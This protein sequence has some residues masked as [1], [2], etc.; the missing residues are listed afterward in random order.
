MCKS[1]DVVVLNAHPSFTRCSVQAGLTP[2]QYSANP[3]A[4]VNPTHA[5]TTSERQCSCIDVSVNDQHITFHDRALSD[6]TKM[7]V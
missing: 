1:F 3:G 4:F 6:R 5:H 7:Y 2:Q